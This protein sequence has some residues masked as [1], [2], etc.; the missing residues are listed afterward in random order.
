[1]LVVENSGATLNLNNLTIAHGSGGGFG[2]PADEGGAILNSGTLTVTNCTLSDNNALGSSNGGA[3]YN[4]GT[5]TVTNSTLSGN[6]TV[7]GNGGGGGGA[8]CNDGGTL[9]VNNS[10]LSNNSADEGGGGAISSA[11]MLTVTNST[12][13]G[14]S[15]SNGSGGGIF[16]GGMLTVTNSTL[17]DNTAEGND[18][19]GISSSGTG[20]V[21]TVT[22]STFVGNG[23][24][25]GGVGGAIN[26]SG[27]TVAITNCTIVGNSSSGIDGGYGAITSHDSLSPVTVAN[28]MIAGN[29][30]GN[31]GI[32]E[33]SGGTISNGGFN[34]SDDAS[35]GFGASA[36]ANGDTIGD[37][38]SYSNV[39]LDPLGLANNGGPTQT[40]ALESG[41]YAIAA[42]PTAAQKGVVG[43]GCPATDQ[44]GAARPAPGYSACDIGAFEYGGVLATP[45]A[46][47]SLTA[48]A[49][50][51]PTATATATA[52][53]TATA[54]AT[55]T[56]TATS[57]ATA[58]A[59]DTATATATATNTA[60]ATDTSTA[61][62]TATVTA[63]PTAT[64]TTSMSV[65]ASRAFGN[66]AVGQTAAKNVTVYN[67]G[68]T[69]SLVIS[70]ATP[71][72]SEYSLTGGGT[73]G[74]IPVTVAPRTNCTLGV[75]FTPSKVGAHGASLAIDNNTA[76]S[77]RNVTLS[78]TGIAD[79]T[80][81]K[82]SLV[83][84]D[85]EFGLK[86]V[87]AFSVV[88]Y[89]TQQVTLSESFTGTN[90][91]DFSITGGTCTG[92]L[93]AK[94]SCSFYVTFT[95]TALGTES[96][97]VTVADSPDPLS[98]YT[99]ALSTGPT[100][101]A[102]VAPVTL[103]YG[104]LSSATLSKTKDLTVTN[105]SGY[106]LSIGESFSG[107]NAADFAST[108]GTCGAS[109]AAHSSCTI[110][111]TFTPTVGPTPESA[112]M[113]VTMGS[114]PSSP[115]SISLTGTGP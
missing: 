97:T 114:D 65:T 36:A 112:S 78:G 8:I 29:G 115:Y 26:D 20:T 71:S 76:T 94:D 9:T 39:A 86:G 56:P 73:C 40:I 37:N 53:S 45:T 59:T 87:E 19:G 80:T 99:V 67:T 64:P 13:S 88:N 28:S 93:A 38:V 72:D 100:I 21:T 83:F 84:G 74:A 105:L 91:S 51:T 95:P 1:M 31:C 60:T 113:A 89:Q 66:V 24:L 90:A 82:S 48:T 34:I 43:G 55:A 96:A 52:T 22:N 98:P 102:T 46:T 111:V 75:A 5:L 33:F 61:T 69:H 85:V 41:S 104:T 23:A 54:T 62:A 81:T 79:L 57:T 42:I 30:E 106:S 6:S 44:R 35:C 108:G 107:T 15:V 32:Q 4:D 58:T 27:G 18:G 7:Y 101:P 103:A 14:N 10:I 110:A 63:T 109:V 49:T 2:S 77:P 25:S 11:C 70:S 50:A 12:L 3:I 16:A 68:R 92:T 47:P 17:F